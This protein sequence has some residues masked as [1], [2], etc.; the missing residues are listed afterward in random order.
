[1]HNFFSLQFRPRLLGIAWF[2]AYAEICTIVCTNAFHIVCTDVDEYI[3]LVVVF[4]IVRVS[5][6]TTALKADPIACTSAAACVHTKT[7]LMYKY[8]LIHVS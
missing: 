7:K 4:V 2:I 6:E 8:V 1:M 5:T 3:T